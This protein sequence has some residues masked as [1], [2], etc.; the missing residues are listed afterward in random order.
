ML[1]VAALAAAALGAC[2]SQAEGPPPEE[3]ADVVAGGFGLGTDVRQCLLERFEDDPS[4]TIALA[5]GG[6]ASLDDRRAL[7]AALE[8]CIE[9]QTLAEVIAAGAGAGVPGTGDDR[10]A[11]LE[12]EV[13]ALDDDRRALLLVGLALSGDGTPDQLDID[14]GAVTSEL[15]ETCDVA[16][17]DEPAPP[18][19]S[20]A[21][22]TP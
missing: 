5:V 22:T 12:R 7:Q 19:D 17:S 21:T 16:F 8:A 9:P 4:A 15:F 11:C 6:S 13:L 14:L 2:S 10:Q 20:G 18:A 3:A 1:A